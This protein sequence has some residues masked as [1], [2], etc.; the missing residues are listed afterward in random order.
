MPVRS[1]RSPVLK[2]PNATE[3]EGA[4]RAWAERTIASRAGIRRI[5]FFGSYADGT[6]GVGSDLDVIVIIAE[7]DMPFIRR[8]AEWD[9]TDLPVPVDLLVYTESEWTRME[10]SR[11]NAFSTGVHWVFEAS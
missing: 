2:W 11:P 4:F 9:T 7:S 6:W 10:Q 8:A 3:V 1:L 5:G